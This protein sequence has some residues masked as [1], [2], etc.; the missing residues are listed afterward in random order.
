MSRLVLKSP[1]E[2][3]IMD[4]ANFIIQRILD[5]LEGTIR[6]GMTTMEIDLFAE[7]QIR[8]AGVSLGGNAASFL[9][10]F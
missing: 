8:S 10:S 6:A 4:Q 1:A 2:L 5:R 7:E 9:T 3:E